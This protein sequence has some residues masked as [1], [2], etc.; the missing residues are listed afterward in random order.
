MDVYQID[1]SHIICTI[2]IAILSFLSITY[3]TAYEAQSCTPSQHF[4]SRPLCL[5]LPLSGL[6][7]MYLDRLLAQKKMHWCTSLM[8]NSHCIC[9]YN[10]LYICIYLL[11]HVLQK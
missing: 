6:N 3:E 5:C 2:F 9:P 10:V 4:E 8:S 7:T 11:L 1:I